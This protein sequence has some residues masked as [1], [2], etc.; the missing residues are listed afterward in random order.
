MNGTYLLAVDGGQTGTRAAIAAPDGTIVGKGNGG[1]IQHLFGG[2]REETRRA[3]HQAVA[4]ALSA[5]AVEPETIISAACGITGVQA[6]S[7]EAERVQALIHE[8]LH[9]A[10]LAVVPDY[11]INLLGASAGAGGVVVVAGGG[12]VAYAEVDDRTLTVGGWG[13][14]LGDEGG[15]I[16]IGRRAINAAIRAGD[17]R[18]PATAL[19]QSVLDTFGIT[20]LLDLKRLLYVPVPP[21]D[22]IA[23]LVPA[24][25]ALAGS[26]PVARHILQEAGSEL[27]LLAV[28]AIRR[29]LA[30]GSPVGV[31]PTGG[32]FQAAPVAH[33]FQQ[34]LFAGW[35]EAEIRSPRFPPLT[36]AVLLAQ[37]LLA[38]MPAR[39]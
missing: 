18:G 35:P 4:G 16:D 1:P 24:V 31:Y 30:P 9:P 38:G 7:P 19:T 17:G 20:S 36:G 8:I 23:A 5:A 2:I 26:D 39:E 34:S 3:V 6:G 21:R 10:S 22:R 32:V 11:V 14:L 12:S 15:G 25:A 27:A 28:T 29:L 37:R 33:A 13:Y